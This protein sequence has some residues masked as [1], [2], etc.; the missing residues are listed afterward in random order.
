VCPDAKISL[1]QKMPKSVKKN[2]QN[3]SGNTVVTKI[4]VDAQPNESQ[5]TLT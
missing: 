4:I 3:Q 5:I 1:A 2:P